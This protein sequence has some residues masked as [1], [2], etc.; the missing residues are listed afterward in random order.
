MENVAQVA[1]AGRRSGD[2]RMLL[3]AETGRRQVD[4]ENGEL[5]PEAEGTALGLTDSVSRYI[6]LMVLLTLLGLVGVRSANSY[7]APLLHDNA[8]IIETAQILSTGQSYQTY[9]LNIETRLLRATHI[10]GL[11]DTPYVAVLGASHW[12][13]AHRGL[14]RGI[15]MYNAHVHRD[16]YE[17]ILGVTEMFVRADRL[18]E[19]MVITIRDNLFTPVE[20]RTDFLWVPILPYYRAM[21]ERLGINAHQ[22]YIYTVRPRM[23]QSLSLPLLKANIT[24]YL[25]APEKPHVSDGTVH[26]TL[27]TLLPDGSILWSTLHENLFTQERA[28]AEALSFA[29]AKRNSP[30]MIDPAGVFAIDKLLSY[31]VDQGVEVYLAHPPFNPIYWDA[32]QDTPYMEGLRRVEELTQSFLKRYDL[33]MVGG[34]DPYELG[35]SEDQYIDGEHSQPECLGRIIDQFRKLDAATY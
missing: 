17:D 20:S 8:K 4:R 13:E 29:Y 16:Y 7:F 19:R 35:C 3:R 32:M 34:F 14:G 9:D 27:D 22:E 28:R 23:R 1:S 31:L 21:A 25:A 5:V 15:D 33:K 26:P 6:M 11:K 18:P 12:Q 24:R 30:P 10:A 2:R